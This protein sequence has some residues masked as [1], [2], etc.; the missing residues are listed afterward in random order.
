VRPP[1]SAVRFSV[2]P[3]LE[4][5]AVSKD[6]GGLRA[7][8]DVD[9]TLQEGDILG[10]IGPNG[11]GKTTFFNVVTGIFRPSGGTIRFQGEEILSA[12]VLLWARRRK[13]HEITQLG[14]GRTFQ[15]IRLFQN[16]T[17][18]ENVIVGTDAHHRQGVFDAILR[19]P[20]QRREDHE[21]QEDA[22]RL[23]E[24]VGIHRYANE[25]AGNL[26]YGDQRRVEI[27]R[28]LATKPKLLLLDEPAAGMNPTEKGRLT[29][30][31]AKIRD[32]GITILI[33]EHDMRVVMGISHRVV[34]LD[35]GV[36]IAEGE[37]AAIQRDPRVIEAYL[38][39]GAGK[40]VGVDR[41]NTSVTGDPRA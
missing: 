26:S 38:G 37:P 16:M 32:Q 40:Q 17:A 3:L 34:V 35:Y 21:G 30:L 7:L 20:R 36:K 33:I 13:P 4:A 14:I 27:A 25:I 28:A 6:F 5:T 31:I 39:T 22:E 9:L 41:P 24:F 10:M 11:A 18:L 1:P 2:T 15:N 19:T 12:P 23:L 8:R 29:D